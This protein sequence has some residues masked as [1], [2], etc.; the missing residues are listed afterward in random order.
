MQIHEH[1]YDSPLRPVAVSDL[2]ERVDFVRT[3][4]MRVMRDGTDAPLRFGLIQQGRV[5][6]A[7]VR[8][9]E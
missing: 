5:I 6:G 1:E 2:V 8:R 4:M 9:D 3:V 7:S